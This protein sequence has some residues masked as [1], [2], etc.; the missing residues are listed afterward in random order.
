MQ[1]GLMV[2]TMN[3]QQRKVIDENP[4]LSAGKLAYFLGLSRN[5]VISYRYRLGG[6]A[7]SY[8][9]IGVPFMYFN[10]SCA[11]YFV[12]KSRIVFYNGLFGK[13]VNVVDHLI[14]CIE[15]NMFN[16]PRIEHPYLE[17]LKFGE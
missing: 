3:D 5:T 6:V 9:G 16:Q 12:S 11:Q 14:W 17:N 8:S 10:R 7:W 1:P 4:N 15:N 2:L 13:A